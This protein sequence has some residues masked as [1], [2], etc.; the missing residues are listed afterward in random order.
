MFKK[1]AKIKILRQKLTKKL[2][3]MLK[4]FHRKKMIRRMMM[5]KCSW[6]RM[7]KM[8]IKK[9]HKNLSSRELKHLHKKSKK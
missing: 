3:K 5:E 2:L 6:K 1:I 9:A 8:P 4:K 7:Q